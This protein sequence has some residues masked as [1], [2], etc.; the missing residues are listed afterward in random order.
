LKDRDLRR[1]AERRCR[2]EHG[3][4]RAASTTASVTK[5]GISS[6]VIDFILPPAGDATMNAT[7]N[8][9][10]I[11][12]TTNVKRLPVHDNVAC[13]G[14]HTAILQPARRE[15]RRHGT[16]LRARHWFEFE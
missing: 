1:L 9:P 4:G 11:G 5:A 16:R 6:Y 3:T 10:A 15:E 7:R 8:G 2:K 14:A 12:S 13:S